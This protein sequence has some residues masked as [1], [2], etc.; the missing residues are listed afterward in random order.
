MNPWW[1]DPK[2]W[3]AHDPDLR[4][5]V[6]SGLG[7]RPSALRGLR[8]AAGSEADTGPT[9]CTSNEEQQKPCSIIR[10]E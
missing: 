10:N 3:A 1:R 2:S 8:P 9:I 6:A 7:Y 5:A 4:S